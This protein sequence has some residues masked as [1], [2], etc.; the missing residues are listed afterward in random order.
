MRILFSSLGKYVLWLI[1]Y[2]F[3][4]LVSSATVARSPTFINLREVSC[5]FKL[6]PGTYCIVPSTFEPNEEGEFILRVFSETK[7]HMKWVLF[8]GPFGPVPFMLLL[9]Y[10]LPFSLSSFFLDNERKSLLWRLWLYV[11]GK[12]EGEK[13]LLWLYHALDGNNVDIFWGLSC[14]FL[15]RTPSSFRIYLTLFSSLCPIYDLSGS[16]V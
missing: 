15:G 5:R 16:L 10:R 11:Q 7:A 13:M 2:L 6:P 12:E 8:L 3:G 14:S 1:D 4:F 9:P